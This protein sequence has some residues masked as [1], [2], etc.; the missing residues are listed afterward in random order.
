M[1]DV[2]ASF[3]VK[4]FK[5]SDD[6]EFLEALSIYGRFT[7][8]EMKTNT[9]EI[10]HWID[11]YNK[12]YRDR[13]LYLLGFYF[14]NR[15]I[16]Y[17]EIAYFRQE[18]FL[19]I[20]YLTIHGAYRNNSAFYTFL[21][22]V[23]D[24][25]DANRV[26]Y[27]YVITEIAA[28]KN[29]SKWSETSNSLIRLLEMENF[30][31]INALYYQPKLEAN[32]DESLMEATLMIYA[33]NSMSKEIK[34]ETYLLIV[35]TLYFKHY[36]DWDAP[37]L[38]ESEK[39]AFSD[40]LDG[41]LDKITASLTTEAV[42]LNGYKNEFTL[43][44]VIAPSSRSSHINKAIIYTFMILSIMLSTLYFSKHF[45]IGM[46][47]ILIMFVLVIFCAFSFIYLFEERAVTIL[48][49]LPDFAKLFDKSK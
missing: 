45:Q 8:R 35:S 12:T 34:K 24:F 29:E 28:K 17:A 40:H 4:L 30:K 16:G 38:T 25:L 19:V 49:K 3:K 23:F 42:I 48:N 37:F 5:S 7:P 47:E 36:R 27:D 18:R 2:K 15:V 10:I 6:L 43:N 1:C 14:Q 13:Q 33:K 26:E 11:C 20:D 41:L 9:N 31:A 44:G 39:T 32:N 21:Y 46:T 22:L